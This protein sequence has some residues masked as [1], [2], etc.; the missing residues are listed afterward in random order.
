MNWFPVQPMWGCIE[1]LCIVEVCGGIQQDILLDSGW[2]LDNFID[3]SWMFHPDWNNKRFLICCRSVWQLVL[4]GQLHTHWGCWGRFIRSIWQFREWGGGSCHLCKYMYFHY[5]QDTKQLL[6]YCVIHQSV[7]TKN[8]EWEMG[9]GWKREREV[10][11]WHGAVYQKH[12][13]VIMKSV[14]LAMITTDPDHITWWHL[15]Q[16]RFHG[17]GFPFLLSILI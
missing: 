9:V 13:M 1:M 10:S 12:W 15:N 16:I 4:S 8:T 7:R 2:I 3:Y 11:Y 6:P 14:W 5:M 17:I